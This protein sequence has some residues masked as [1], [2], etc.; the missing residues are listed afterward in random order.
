M[1]SSEDSTSDE[2]GRASGTRG[3]KDDEDIEMEEELDDGV[4]RELLGGD[5]DGDGSSSDSMGEGSDVPLEYDY[6]YNPAELVDDERRLSSEQRERIAKI[7]RAAADV[8]RVIERYG[9]APLPPLDPND[10]ANRHGWKIDEDSAWSDPSAA[11][12][13]IVNAGEELTKAWGDG[14]VD[15]AEGK[16]NNQK[17][18]WWKPI[19]DG[20]S[21]K[22]DA[23][24]DA[25]EQRLRDRATSPPLTDEEMNQFQSTHLEWATE[26]FA[27]ELD[28]LRTGRLE[29][30]VCAKKKK[31]NEPE[32]GLDPA[33][34]SLVATPK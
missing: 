34:F 7:E 8:R 3:R 28:A 10:D 27:E 12:D 24:T 32:A 18:E 11:M 13:E 15:G 2:G 31:K 6:E 14:A 19:I 4:A 21:S 33:Q 30:L 1:S 26:A 9:K 22:K 5:D 16:K 23:A 17:E 29:E 25:S 20:E